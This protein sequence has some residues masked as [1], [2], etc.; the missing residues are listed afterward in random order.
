MFD[1]TGKMLN[2]IQQTKSKR[3]GKKTPLF[4][5][6]Y[7]P[8]LI[9]QHTSENESDDENETKRDQTGI[10]DNE[11]EDLINRTDS[12]D[13]LKSL[14]NNLLSQNTRL[15]DLSFT[16]SYITNLNDKI[17][18]WEHCRKDIYEDVKSE[19]LMDE[20]YLFEPFLFPNYSASNKEE[21]TCSR[22]E[23]QLKSVDKIT[24]SDE[25]TSNIDSFKVYVY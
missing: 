15:S 1:I 13:D 12:F 2:L 11:L 24:V 17:F 3:R 16:P 10:T 4:T 20:N 21:S 25:T 8:Y 6:I 9:D 7:A 18:S 22:G 5:H 23:G 14:Q 19:M